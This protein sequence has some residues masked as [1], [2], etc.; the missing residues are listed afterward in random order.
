VESIYGVV[1]GPI[2]LRCSAYG[3]HFNRTTQMYVR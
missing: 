1:A 3:S 2:L